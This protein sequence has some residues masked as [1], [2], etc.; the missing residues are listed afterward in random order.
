MGELVSCSVNNVSLSVA[1]MTCVQ[2]LLRRCARDDTAHV[3]FEPPN[4][5][6]GGGSGAK[7]R[8]NVDRFHSVCIE[9]Q[10]LR[11]GDTGQAQ[12]ARIDGPVNIRTR[13][14][15]PVASL[16]AIIGVGRTRRFE[17]KYPSDSLK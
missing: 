3:I 11:A 12:K 9:L 6:A 15:L 8:V 2:A 10:V 17:L 4:A 14:N 1:S 13:L 5:R 16:G 7:P